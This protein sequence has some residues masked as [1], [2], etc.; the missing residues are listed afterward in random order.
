[1]QNGTV[2]RIIGPVVDVRFPRGAMPPIDTLLYAVDG[3][4]RVALEVSQHLRDAVRCIAL[5]ATEGL[6]RGL[7]VENTGERHPRAGGQRHAVPH[8]QRAGRAHRRQGR[9]SLGRDAAHPPRR[10]LLHRAAPSHRDL[11]NRHQGHRPARALRARRQD[12]PVRRR[13]RGQDGA[14]PGDDPQHRHR[15][16]RPFGVRRRG[17]A[18]PRGQRPFARHESVVA[19]STRLPWC[20]A[21]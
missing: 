1:M 5:E 9:D 4:R 17:G 21:R 3:D 14:D 18:Q 12:R 16:R 6:S 20:S 2:M 11:R 19:S 10:A 8:G 15:A 13:R 7:P